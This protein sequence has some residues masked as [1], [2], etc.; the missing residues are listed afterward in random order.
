MSISLVVGTRPEILKMAPI[1]FELIKRNIDFE[2]IHTG[3]H[4]DYLLS[5]LF[6]EEL[7]LPSPTSS[8]ELQA[9]NPAA[10]IGEMMVKLEAVLSK[11]KSELLLIQGDTNTML[12]A[13][14]V[15]LK[16]GIKIAHVEAGLR[17]FDW[18]MPEEHNRR[19]VDHV[20][21]YLFAPT[22]LSKSNLVRELVHGAI[23]VTGNTILDS[24]KLFSPLA[25]RKST[26]LPKLKFHKFVLAT[27]HR[28]ENVDD[29]TILKECIHAFEHSPLPVV[30]PAHP[31]TLKRLEEYGISEELNSNDN[32]QILTP[33]GYFDFLVLMKNC[34]LI[35]TDSGGIQEEA[36]SPEILK[37][38]VVLRR[39]TERPEAIENG[40]ARLVD[41]NSGTIIRVIEQI[42]RDPPSLSNP[43]PFGD[44]KASERIVSSL[45]YTSGERASK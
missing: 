5:K 14:L 38:V 34:E 20:S 36:T 7:G 18:R 1:V 41:L 27:I 29:P 45:Y 26:V 23:F 11:T 21:D 24:V 10:Q 33:Q 30:F 4:H 28:S 3:Q 31:R 17:S 22:E 35:L 16:V 12:A 40:F 6:V 44:G 25:D 32:V 19:M 37:P 42:I 2:L 13:S 9:E 43:S 39:S 15:G 8:F